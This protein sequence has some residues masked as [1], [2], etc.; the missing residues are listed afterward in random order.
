MVIT[1]QNNCSCH[2]QDR[3]KRGTEKG[4][5]PNTPFKD[6][7]AMTKDLP[8]D[9]TFLRFHLLPTVP[10][11]DNG[12]LNMRFL[13]LLIFPWP[14]FSSRKAE[15]TFSSCLSGLT[16]PLWI[17]CCESS[18]FWKTVLSSVGLCGTILI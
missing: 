4:Q 3:E 9:S 7:P 10:L 1:W 6:I 16:R 14:H 17:H 15:G 18:I 8:L 12:A 2:G 5:V 13:G 11:A